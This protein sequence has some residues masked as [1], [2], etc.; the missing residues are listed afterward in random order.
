MMSNKGE[1]VSSLNDYLLGIGEISRDND[2]VYI[3]CLPT[4]LYFYLYLFEVYKKQKVSSS[5][6]F[7]FMMIHVYHNILVLQLGK[8]PV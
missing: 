8:Y 2:T 4:L 7:L 1:C 6:L 3:V 5:L